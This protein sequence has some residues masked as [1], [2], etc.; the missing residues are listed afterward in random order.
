[1]RIVYL[2]QYFRTPD[3]SGGTRSY[4]FGRRLAIAGHD[5]HVVTS[6]SNLESRGWC[7]YEVDGMTV[8]ALRVPYNNTMSYPRRIWSFL[9]FALRSGFYAR[10]LRGDLVYATSTPLT[11]A[12][13]GVVAS[14]PKI[15]MVFEVRDLWPEVPIALGAIRGRVLT[16]LARKLAAFAY[17]HSRA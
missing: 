3:M 6:S 4:E 15:P 2:H 8:H 11:I 10:R 1:M 5:V 9:S 14:W 13:P 16:M 17:R 7:T 12:I